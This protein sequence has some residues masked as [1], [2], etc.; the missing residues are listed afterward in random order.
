MDGSLRDKWREG[1][2]RGYA[3]SV[4]FGRRTS[5][6]LLCAELTE[7]GFEVLELLL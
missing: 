1:E 4:E 6:D 3:H 5:G 2:Q 7:L